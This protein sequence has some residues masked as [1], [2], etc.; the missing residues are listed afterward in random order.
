MAT[1]KE[2][3]PT[4]HHQHGDLS[5]PEQSY[6]SV[7]AVRSYEVGS[8]G[9]VRPGDLL[10]Y[11]EHLATTAS[12]SLGF[13]SRWYQE[14]NGAWV[15]R[16]MSL[17]FGAAPRIDDELRLFSW[18]SDFRRVQS[19]RDYLITQADTGRLVVRASAR[20]AYIDRTRL[21]PA[22]IPEEIIAR[23]G[24]W[25]HPLRERPHPQPDAAAPVVHTLSLTAREYEADSQRHINNCVYLDWFSEAA[26]LAA[27][28]GRFTG[29]PTLLR[30]RFAH[31]EYL[32]PGMP[33]D[34]VTIAVSAPA[35][36]RS[37]SVGFWQNAITPDGPIAR[38]WMES[39]IGAR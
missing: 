13:D 26:H 38:A 35:R 20:W 25:G 27:M 31:L 1:S 32:R 14:R 17:L 5:I 11:I 12:A 29:A 3:L 37:R 6:R 22:R 28:Q 34:A 16:E 2:H 21:S 15:V 10:R 23:M 18:V 19:T 36:V 9:T 8:E 30:P 39:L 4:P 7:L 33:G 24:P